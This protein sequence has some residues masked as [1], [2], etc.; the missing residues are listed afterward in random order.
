ML[1][2]ITLAVAAASASA[3]G[4]YTYGWTFYVDPLCAV[5]HPG[6]APPSIVRECPRCCSGCASVR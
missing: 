3:A 5:A 4:S 1:K 6:Q 2:L